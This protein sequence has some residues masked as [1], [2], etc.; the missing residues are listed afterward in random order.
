[1]KTLSH[2]PQWPTST[3]VYKTRLSLQGKARMENS[4]FS[5]QTRSGDARTDLALFGRITASSEESLGMCKHMSG[6]KNDIPPPGRNPRRCAFVQIISKKKC[7][8]L[9]W[10]RAQCDWRTKGKQLHNVVWTTALWLIRPPVHQPVAIFTHL[11]PWPCTVRE[12]TSNHTD[13][14][15]P[16]NCAQRV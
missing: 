11:H 9:V 13:L 4:S 1:M 7:R 10:P 5:G 6:R 3:C 8:S 16:V 2:A 12:A 14:L 15:A